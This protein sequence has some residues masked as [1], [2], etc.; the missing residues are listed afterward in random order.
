MD[1]LAGARVDPLARAALGDV[2]AAEA[3]KSNLAAPPQGI[4]DRAQHRVDRTRGLHFA[5]T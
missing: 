2:K 5:Q 1:A 3:G 4:L